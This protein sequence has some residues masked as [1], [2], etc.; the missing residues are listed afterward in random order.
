VL[1]DHMGPWVGFYLFLHL[2]PAYQKLRTDLT[3]HVRLPLVPRSLYEKY[4]E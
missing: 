4:P 3:T 2:F 1:W